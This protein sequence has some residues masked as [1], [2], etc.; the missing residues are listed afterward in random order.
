M[1]RLIGAMVSLRVPHPYDLRQGRMW[2]SWDCVRM[3]DYARA[4]S[5]ESRGIQFLPPRAD[6]HTTTETLRGHGE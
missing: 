2:C 6:V 4:T 5:R 3:C 1:P